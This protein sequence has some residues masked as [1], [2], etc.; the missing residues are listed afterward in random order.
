MTEIKIITKNGFNAIGEIED[1]DSKNIYLR[2]YDNYTLR[3]PIDDIIYPYEDLYQDSYSKE[4]L[5]K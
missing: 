2:I 1:R 5:Y 3:I 4:N